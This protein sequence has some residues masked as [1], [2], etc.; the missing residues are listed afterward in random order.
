[1]F[2]PAS[3]LGAQTGGEKLAELLALRQPVV[4]LFSPGSRPDT[5]KIGRGHNGNE[6]K[7]FF[8][9]NSF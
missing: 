3:S 5:T 8:G 4:K 9:K 6:S 2:L 7:I 1:M